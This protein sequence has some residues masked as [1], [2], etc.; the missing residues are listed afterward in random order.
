MSRYE[1]YRICKKRKHQS[2]GAK[3]GDWKV[4]KFCGTLFRFIVKMEEKDTPKQ[5]A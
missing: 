1:E 3:D 4:C 2:S 5:N